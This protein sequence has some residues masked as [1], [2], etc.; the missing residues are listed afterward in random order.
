VRRAH[1]SFSEGAVAQLVE[2]RTENPCVGGSIPPHTTKKTS[3]Y[4]ENYSRFFHKRV[5]AD[6][7]CWTR[8]NILSEF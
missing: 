3:D 2:Q 4:N 7:F 8:L 6:Y 1:R 5:S